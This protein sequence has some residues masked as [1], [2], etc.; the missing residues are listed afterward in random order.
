[1]TLKESAELWF[2]EQGVITYEQKKS[3]EINK[4]IVKNTSKKD[5]N[6]IM[7]DFDSK[8]ILKM[9][10]DM[11]QL[12]NPPIPTVQEERISH[13]IK[14]VLVN[15]K[16][17]LNGKGYNELNPFERIIFNTLIIQEREAINELLNI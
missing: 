17:T 5:L 10:T 1:M 7:K 11:T 8:N 12:V 16:V 2:K 15:G 13:E 3:L 14:L 6:N 9:K 4:N